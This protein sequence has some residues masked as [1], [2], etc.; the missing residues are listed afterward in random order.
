VLVLISPVVEAGKER[1]DSGPS[2]SQHAAQAAC[3][4]DAKDRHFGSIEDPEGNTRYVLVE[5]LCMG[6]AIG[7][8]ERVLGVQAPTV[9]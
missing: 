4:A 1:T 7:K 6:V 5:R 3:C 8:G 2:R 9:R